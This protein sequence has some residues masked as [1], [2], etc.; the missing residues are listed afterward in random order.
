MNQLPFDE[1]TSQR[2]E[3][4]YRT[5]DALRRRRLVREAI[6]AGPGERILDVGCGGGFYLAELLDAVGAEGSLVGVDSSAAM[7]AMAA[8]RCEGHGN[9]TFREADATALPVGDADFD[10]AFSVQVLEYVPDVSAAL[11]EVHRALRP[12]GRIVVWDID[13]ATVS[14]Y[15]ADPDR[16]SRVLRAWDDHLADPSLPR[17]LATRMRAAG[18]GDVTVQGH[19]FATGESDP[20]TYGVAMIP[21]I[22]DF[23]AGRAE[24]GPDEAAAW[25]AEQRDL[26]DGNEFFF[27][28]TQFCFQ[29]TKTH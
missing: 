24:V 8:R 9:V 15:S 20:E 10:A 18:F 16:M 23:V 27:S 1:A 12:G 26:G 4:L 14:W 25:A 13:W 7:L 22:E 2:L 6:A 28:C 17:T 3:R 21:L 19:V 5:R 11:V 29:G